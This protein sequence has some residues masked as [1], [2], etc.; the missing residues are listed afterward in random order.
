MGSALVLFLGITGSST[1]KNIM[2]LENVY[3]P[4]SQPAS[5]KDRIWDKCV[6]A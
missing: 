3:I 2:M 6:I 4:S 1:N 5:Q